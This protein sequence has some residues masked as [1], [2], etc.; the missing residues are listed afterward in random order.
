M[1]ARR[2]ARAGTEHAPPREPRDVG[3][4]A[5]TKRSGAVGHSRAR[6][7][8]FHG[9]QQMRPRMNISISKN[10]AVIAIVSHAAVCA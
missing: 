1:Q 8:T 10:A 3:R 9:R 7:L 2:S 5:R 4:A 6:Q